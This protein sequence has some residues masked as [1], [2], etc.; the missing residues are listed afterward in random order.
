MNRKNFFIYNNT[1]YNFSKSN[2]Y[3]KKE[4]KVAI[5]IPEEYKEILSKN[6]PHPSV[7]SNS[8]LQTIPLDKFL[9]TEKIDGLNKHLLIFDKKVYTISKNP[10]LS[11]N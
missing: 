9:Y 5:N 6:W 2:S 7:L 3:K 1:S 11:L 8:V 4:N 10:E